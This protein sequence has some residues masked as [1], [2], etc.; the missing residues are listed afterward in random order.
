MYYHGINAE[1]LQFH[2]PILYPKRSEQQRNSEQLLDAMHLIAC[3]GF[4]PV[5]LL[6]CSESYTRQ[7]CIRECGKFGDTVFVFDKLPLPI[8]YLSSHERGVIMLDLREA[9]YCYATNIIS[10]RIVHKLLPDLQ[11]R[12]NLGD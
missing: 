1:Y 2:F 3:F 4:E 7:E 12:I 11:I 5:H 6:Q 8:L 10:A 9:K